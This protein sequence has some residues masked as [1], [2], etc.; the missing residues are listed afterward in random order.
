[1][2]ANIDCH[3]RF[4]WVV[5]QLES[6]QNCVTV[7]ALKKALH[8]LPKTL[9][10]TYDRILLQIDEEYQEIALKVLQWLAYSVRPLTLDEV[11]EALAVRIGT[12]TIDPDDRLMDPRDILTVCSSLVTTTYDE[13]F[14]ETIRL[15][16][17]SVK[18]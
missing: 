2:E 18:E 7:A 14:N 6:L 10:D 4:R 16:H 11:A 5:C 3:R 1:M 12:F 13:K 8:T 15:A 17:Y 9:P